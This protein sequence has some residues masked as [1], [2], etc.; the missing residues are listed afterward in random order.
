MFSFHVT[1]SSDSHP[2]AQFIC[3]ESRFYGCPWESHLLLW[4]MRLSCRH[5]L[6]T[7]CGSCTPRWWSHSKIQL[8]SLYILNRWLTIMH[9]SG[10]M[11]LSVHYIFYAIPVYLIS[12]TFMV[13]WSWTLHGVYHQVAIVRKCFQYRNVECSNQRMNLGGWMGGAGTEWH[14]LAICLLSCGLMEA[15]QVCGIYLYAA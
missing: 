11:E 9:G 12:Y 2:V 7:T 14:F 8:H 15:L 6:N 13:I 10:F 4:P 5:A 3:P 1:I